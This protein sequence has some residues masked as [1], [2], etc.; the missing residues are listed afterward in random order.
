[1][2]YIAF[3]AAVLLA[4]FSLVLAGGAVNAVM[5]A[6]AARKEGLRYVIA[7]LVISAAAVLFGAGSMAMLEVAF[8]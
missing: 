2:S 6:M 7:F 8:A 3:G 1:M 4:K 5:D